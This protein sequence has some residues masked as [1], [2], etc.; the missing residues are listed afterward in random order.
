MEHGRGLVNLLPLRFGDDPRSMQAIG[1]EAHQPR[2]RF[3]P[4]RKDHAEIE[5]CLVWHERAIRIA[6]LRFQSRPCA[7]PVVDGQRE[8]ADKVSARQ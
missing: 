8:M 7:F 1:L 4:D 3:I 2:R 6:A 5:G